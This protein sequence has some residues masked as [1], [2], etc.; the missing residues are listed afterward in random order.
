MNRSPEFPL[1]PTAAPAWKRRLTG[2]WAAAAVLAAFLVLMLASLREK[3]LTFD[4]IGHATAGYTYWQFDDYRLDPENGNLPQRIAGLPLLWGDFRFPSIDSDSWRQSDFLPIGDAWFNRM[5][6]DV[7]AMLARGRAACGLVAVALGALVW[8]WS[9]RLHGPLGGM[10]S[11]ALFVLSPTVLANGALMTSD[12]TAAFFFFAACMALWAALHRLSARRVLVSALAMAGLFVSKSSAVLIIP[13]ALALVAARLVD[14]RPLPVTLG[15]SRELPRRGQQAAAFALAALAHAAVVILVV[16]A[17]YGFRFSAFAAS[18][19]APARMYD[20]WEQ[21]MEKPPLG[22]LLNDLRLSRAQHAAVA[23]MLDQDS[24][25]TNQWTQE[26]LN[27]IP[28]LERSV[29]TPGQARRLEAER[30]VPPARPILR[31]L[32]WFYRHHL[33]PQAYL[34]GQAHVGSSTQVRQA[35]LNGRY[36]LTGWKSFFPYTVLV[37]TPLPVFGVILLAIGAAAAKWRGGGGQRGGQRFFRSFYD[38]L[39][40]WVLLGVYWAVFINAPINIGHRHIL[41][42][43]PPLFVLAGAAAAWPGARGRAIRAAVAALLVLLAAEVLYR[44]P[45]YLA[46]FNVIAGGPP[47]AYRH[48]VDSSLDWGQDLPG[49]KRYIDEHHVVAP[50]YL[51][52]FGVG[53]PG[54]YHIPAHLLYSFG[55]SL[56][57]PIP[58]PIVAVRAPAEKLGSI[59]DGILAGNPELEFLATSGDG[60]QMIAI[61]VEKPEFYRLA[62]GTYFISATLLQSLEFNTD[63]PWGP[64]NDRYEAEYQRLY[65][66]TRPFMSDDQAPRVEALEHSRVDEWMGIFYDFE[67]YRFA[68][69]AA[70]LRRREPD[71]SVGYSILVYRLTD[72]DVSRALDGPPPERGPD[73]MELLEAAHR[74]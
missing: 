33:L 12:A 11:L 45:N 71:D 62:G 1:A 69:L 26:A 56:V 47:R 46:Y 57:H 13:I 53:D 10:L 58:D 15:R 44:F 41:P 63:R 64:W 31:V 49:V 7:A 8:L 51:S 21:M 67:Q 52:Y 38:T 2:P 54:Y 9:R 40:L 60:G 61:L 68:R 6:N 55:F 34:F 29:L 43:Y 32:D 73:V 50:V 37:K 5:G 18:Q 19:P 70:Y 24:I 30:A 39:P 4:E 22:A 14:G 17:C 42:T 66:L 25:P 35:F 36:S 28:V 16:W 20:T 59:V 27:I 74:P 48:L 3:S 65:A 23:R 72:A